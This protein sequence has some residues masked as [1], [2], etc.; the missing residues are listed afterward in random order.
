M[1]TPSTQSTPTAVT[2]QEPPLTLRDHTSAAASVTGTI[3]IH[4]M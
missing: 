3:A 1:A 2:S 4:A